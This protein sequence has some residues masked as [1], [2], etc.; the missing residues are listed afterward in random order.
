MKGRLVFG[1]NG[2]PDRYYIDNKEVT[3]AEWD[4]AFPPRPI[5]TGAGLTAWKRPVKSEALAVHP[6]QVQKVLERNRKH[7]VHI[8]YDH[9]GRPIFKSSGDQRSLLE[10]E[11]AVNLDGSY[12][13]DHGNVNKGYLE[14]TSPTDFEGV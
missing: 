14:E 6:S 13:T 10:I 2:A 11:G 1:E 7:G 4:R 12:G 3:K 9:Q 5:G 8:D